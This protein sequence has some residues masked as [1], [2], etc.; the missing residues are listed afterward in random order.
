MGALRPSMVK[1]TLVY[2]KNL[3]D[4]KIS[5]AKRECIIQALEKQLPHEIGSEAE[6]AIKLLETVRQN[7][8]TEHMVA[9]MA[10]D[11]TAEDREI[12]KETFRLLTFAIECLRRADN[13]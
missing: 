7:L 10:G 5:P 2:I 12:Y 1:S 11:T 9:D 6:K 8:K 3:P 4:D 13:P